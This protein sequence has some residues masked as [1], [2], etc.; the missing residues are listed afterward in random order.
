MQPKA[1]EEEL[2]KIKQDIFKN[3][4][5][6][7]L[8]QK[9]KEDIQFINIPKTV[10]ETIDKLRK[11]NNSK[12][13]RTALDLERSYLPEIT[14]DDLIRGTHHDKW[15]RKLVQEYWKGASKEESAMRELVNTTGRYNLSKYQS[16]EPYQKALN[17]KW[18]EF[19]ANKLG[20]AAQKVGGLK[21]ALRKDMA[22][23]A[24]GEPILRDALIKANDTYANKVIPHK[25]YLGGKSPF[26]KN[27]KTKE[28][29]SRQFHRRIYQARCSK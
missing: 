15:A 1:I 25:E 29:T 4:E 27:Y 2:G 8:S 11:Q 13:L 9:A 21:S 3:W 18:N 14:V 6:S 12:A 5:S 17:E 10:K 20:G 22:D 23:S 19:D 7:T 16:A 26:Y 24:E 28:K